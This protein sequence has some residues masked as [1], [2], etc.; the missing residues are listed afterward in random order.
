[1]YELSQTIPD[2]QVLLAMEP[3]ELGAKI[4]FLL[5]KGSGNTI[6]PQ[7]PFLFSNLLMELWPG[8][9]YGQQPPYP[10][11]RRDE[12]DLALAEAWAWL[13][14]QGLLVPSPSSSGGG[15]LESTQPPGAAI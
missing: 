11:Q 14:A 1:M 15:R 12:I 4:L 3:E 6:R 8:D 10:Q 9:R 2:A 7:Q 5:R 13:V